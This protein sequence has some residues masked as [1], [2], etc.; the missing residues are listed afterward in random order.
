MNKFF[1]VAIGAFILFA[2]IIFAGKSSSSVVLLD[3]N[4]FTNKYKEEPG[5][6]MIDVRTP[7]EFSNGHIAKAINIDFQNPN[8][9][10]EIKKLDQS[11]NYF[12]YCQSGNRSSQAVRKMQSLG[13][14]NMFE[15]HG[16]LNS[17]LSLI[18]QS[19]R[20]SN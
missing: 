1:L 18:E 13:I 4:L 5:S 9:E 15:L 17:N 19:S 16:G 8:F 12:V 11:G 20:S 6:V 10:T 2:V 3:S 14:K 7:S